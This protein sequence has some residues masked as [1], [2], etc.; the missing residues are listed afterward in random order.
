VILPLSAE[1]I[2]RIDRLAA[3]RGITRAAALLLCAGAGAR[4]NDVEPE[5]ANDVEGTTKK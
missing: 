5:P 3:Q 4:A 2:A 1:D